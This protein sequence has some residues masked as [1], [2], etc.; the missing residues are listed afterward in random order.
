VVIENGQDHL[1]LSFPVTRIEGVMRIH[2]A[3]IG[4]VESLEEV[5][6]RQVPA[7]GMD[8]CNPGASL[9]RWIHNRAPVIVTR[10]P[11]EGTRDNE[12]AAG[13]AKISEDAHARIACKRIEQGG[14]GGPAEPNPKRPQAGGLGRIDGCGFG[15]R[16]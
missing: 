5:L 15:H 10:I 1:A 8:A 14:T 11:G 9:Y 12:T 6:G 4:R 3:V 2:K 7:V 13:I 16:G